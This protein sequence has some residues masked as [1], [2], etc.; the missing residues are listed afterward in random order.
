[1]LN[2]VHLIGYVGRDP[3]VRSTSNGDRVASVSIA[4]T[5]KWK[6]RNSGERREATEW[7]RV[8][9]FGQLAEIAETFVQKGT[10]LLVRGKIKTRKWTDQA[11]A[12]RYTTEIVLSGYDSALKVLA[13][14]ARMGQ[15]EDAGDER[16][17]NEG[18]SNGRGVARGNGG[19]RKPAPADDEPLD[20]D[21]PF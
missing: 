14:G 11:G 5:E 9:I 20:D 2:E 18:R 8:V 15:G 21:I 4:T 12:E 6:D 13:N 3:E 17:R 19:G 7:H 1:M 10:L 16:G